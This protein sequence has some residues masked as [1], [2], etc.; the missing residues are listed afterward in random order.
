MNHT[1]ET[2]N[3]VLISS[4]YDIWTINP[5]KGRL[6]HRP[7]PAQCG[8]AASS[9]DRS[10]RRVAKDVK[11]IFCS[12]FLRTV[13]DK[14]PH[15]PLDLLCQKHTNFGS[16]V[17][18]YIYKMMQDFYHQQ[19]VLFLCYSRAHVKNREIRLRQV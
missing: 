5:F 18:V 16:I 12:S 7:T 19:Y 14:Q 15:G 17:H 6:V 11:R 8:Q 2:I 9:R 10:P 3:H 4:Q 13:D 1:S